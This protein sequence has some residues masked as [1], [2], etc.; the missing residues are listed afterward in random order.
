MAII[1]QSPPG[2]IGCIPNNAKSCTYDN[3]YWYYGAGIIPPNT[4]KKIF[5]RNYYEHII[6][7]EIEYNTIRQYIQNNPLNWDTDE[8]NT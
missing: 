5:Q 6:R 8:E 7:N 2:K 1:A 4:I 3:S